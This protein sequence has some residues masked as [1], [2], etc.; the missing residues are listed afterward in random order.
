MI[1]L[2]FKPGKV[3]LFGTYPGLP[4]LVN[5]GMRQNPW[6]LHGSIHTTPMERLPKAE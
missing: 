4:I 1:F 5:L 3:Y 6:E 2:L